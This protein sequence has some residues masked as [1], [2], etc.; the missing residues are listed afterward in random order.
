MSSAAIFLFFI[1]MWGLGHL[2]G[3]F[4]KLS[5]NPF[6]REFTRLAFGLGFFSILAIFFNLV[7]IPL[8]WVAFLI[9][10]LI[11]PLISIRKFLGKPKFSTTLLTK[12]NLIFTIILILA[13]VHL[14]VFLKGAF[15]Y[16]WLEDGDPWD[17]SRSI[18]YIALERTAFEPSTFIDLY[19]Y[20]DP[21]PPVFD[22]LMAV[23]Y[24]VS[25]NLMWTL[26]FFNS[27]LISLS[28]VFFF[29][30]TK[31]L[32]NDPIKALFAT[33]ILF[34]I[35][36]Y[37]S[38]FIWAISLAMVI[39]LPCLYCLENIRDDKKWTFPSIILI[40]ALLV[41]QP[42]MVLVLGITLFLYW[43]VKSLVNMDWHKHIIIA[44][45]L[46]ITVSMLWWGPM[47]IRWGSPLSNDWA[48]IHGPQDIQLQ[49]RLPE[50]GPGW[51]RIVGTADRY[52]SFNDFFIAP[53]VNTINNPTGVGQVLFM[54]LIA[55]LLYSIFYFKTL[56][57]K[58][59]EWKVLCLVLLLFTF[60]GIHG[61]RLPVQFIAFR[62]WMLFAIPVSVLVGGVLTEMIG[63]KTIPRLVLLVLVFVGIAMTSGIPKY[64]INTSTW[65]PGF[66]VSQ[67]EVDS[68]IKFDQL[69]PNHQRI[70]SVCPDSSFK[71]AA[72]DQDEC[73][74]C[75]DQLD[76]KKGIMNESPENISAFLKTKRYKYL[77][78]DVSCLT[79]YPSY[80]LNLKADQ[81][82]QSGL[83][84]IAP[85]SKELR[86][87]VL[88]TPK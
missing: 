7:H 6:E 77:L 22:I 69:V 21:Y 85:E 76:F 3:R 42:S 43:L 38:H 17:H 59:N 55:S 32:T 41:S 24:Q 20:M 57:T 60:L 44:G 39:F 74:W 28:I 83:F 25:D 37:M 10:S 63:T 26:K 73:T 62:F 82:S 70:F 2:L 4:V 29:M 75:I 53:P 8:H 30:F 13:I 33:L 18:R 27:L 12:E 48:G 34:L 5:E 51:F 1:M 78:F 54:M 86:G 46:G 45:I 87:I 16:P 81:L 72:Y 80:Y 47:F 35:P 23:L 56:F 50:F 9:P 31:K 15:S 52:Y 84:E 64:K 66:M 68:Y 65:G 14:S 88:L 71:L 36:S 79:V 19:K 67:L 49:K 61:A 11:S 40:A 58:E